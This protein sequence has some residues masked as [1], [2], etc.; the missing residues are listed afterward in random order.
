MSAVSTVNFRGSTKGG[1][2]QEDNYL[3]SG[4]CPETKE[5]GRGMGGGRKGGGDRMG[6]L[7]SCWPTLFLIMKQNPPSDSP[8]FSGE[9][10]C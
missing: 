2:E 5:E 10:S 7:L 3:T 6:T 4:I 8:L 1:K 9:W